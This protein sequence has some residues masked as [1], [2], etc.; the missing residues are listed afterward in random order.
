MRTIGNN[1]LHYATEDGKIL[2]QFEYNEK[3]EAKE[4]LNVYSTV[5]SREYEPRK[6]NDTEMGASIAK[7]LVIMMNHRAPS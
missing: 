4:L 1:S 2:V 3:I 6:Y 7:S 5:K